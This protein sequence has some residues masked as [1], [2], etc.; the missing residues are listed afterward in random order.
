MKYLIK[1][2]VTIVAICWASTAFAQNVSK[3]YVRHGSGAPSTCPLGTVYIDDVTGF[4]YTNK[5][6]SCFASG[7][8]AGVTNSA[9]NGQV[10][11]SNG[12]NLVGDADLTFSVDT[13][14]ATKLTTNGVYT[15]TQNALGT[16]STD[17]LILQN[18]TAAAGSAP[19]YSPRMRFTG[20]TWDGGTSQ[21]ADWIIENQPGGT[22]AGDLLQFSA[23]VGAGGYQSIIGVLYNGPTGNSGL[24]FNSPVSKNANLI[25]Q[26]NAVN[27][28]YVQN[29]GASADEYRILSSDATGNATL[30]Q[31][32][33]ATTGAIKFGGSNYTT[34]TAL[35][36]SANVI[37][38][39]VSDEKVKRAITPFKL[40]ALSQLRI[41]QPITFRYREGTQWFNGRN[42]LG[43]SA[44]NLQRANPLLVSTFTHDGKT[45]LQP[46]PLAIQALTIEAV[47]QLDAR[48][49]ALERENHRLR[50]VLRRRHQ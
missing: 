42:Q 27:K 33:N 9:A 18:T 36:T 32:A 20:R 37:T 3:V 1:L 29:V 26:A 48:V 38:C 47:K 49:T 28:W 43:L 17:G 7:G 12:T 46:E 19:Q 21:I 16:V 14:T 34:C 2:L 4:S 40:D 11:I 10:A 39:T 23:Q 22:Q 5:A 24:N 25:Y 15:D 13:L 8:G 50:A 45:L 31:I 35:T 44:Q 6:G 41:I 30:F